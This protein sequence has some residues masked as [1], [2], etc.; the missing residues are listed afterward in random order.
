MPD[1]ATIQPLVSVVLCTFNGEKYLRP[2]LDSILSQSWTNLEVII[3]DDASTDGTVSIIK[4]YGRK[5]PRIRV[6]VNEVN[7]GYNKNFEK[8]FSHASSE[9]I[10]ISDQDDIWES[11]KIECIMKQWLP[12]SLFMY[13]LSGSFYNDDFSS[14]K[15]APAVRYGIITQPHHIGPSARFMNTKRS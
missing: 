9:H 7:S 15:P 10:A 12:G 8:A 4:E 11:N 3:S 14:R 5:D 6:F 1:Q 2:Q 13:S